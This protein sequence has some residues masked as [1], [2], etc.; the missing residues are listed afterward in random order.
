M[1]SVGWAL[2]WEFWRKGRWIIIIISLFLTMFVLIK[3]LEIKD[4]QKFCV[5][6]KGYQQQM[7]MMGMEK[8]YMEER[9]REYELKID[10]E[11][12]EFPLFLILVLG[13]TIIGIPHDK[14]RLPHRLFTLPISTRSLVTR[15]F[16]NEIASIM[17]L[18]LVY[19]GFFVFL[20]GKTVSIFGISLFT[21]TSIITIQSFL[22]LT[23]SSPIIGIPLLLVMSFSLFLWF[24]A[25][26]G[27]VFF[28]GINSTWKNLEPDQGIFMF[29][30]VILSYI[31]AM[32]AVA[33]ERVKEN[34]SISDI[35]ELLDYKIRSFF[36]IRKGK[37]KSPTKAQ[38]WFEW[39]RQG[40]LMP[41]I[42]LLFMVEF[43]ILFSAGIAPPDSIVD[44]FNFPFFII[45]I[46]L[47]QIWGMLIAKTNPAKKNF[48]LWSFE[49]TRPL[50][51]REISYAILKNGAVNILLT[52]LILIFGVIFAVA[53]NYFLGNASFIKNIGNETL[54]LYPLNLE[55]KGIRVLIFI[56][57]CFLI[58]SWILMGISSAIT[59]MGKRTFIVLFWTISCTVL[60]IFYFFILIGTPWWGVFLLG[61]IFF[62]VLGRGLILEIAFI[63]FITRRRNLIEREDVLNNF[64]LWAIGTVILILLFFT[65]NIQ[66][67]DIV[68]FL[69]GIIALALSPFALA[70]LALHWNR[71]R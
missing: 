5:E 68:I 3:K 13:L 1:R 48:S 55:I 39:Q 50:S 41:F 52:G 44:I 51:C 47:S 35:S 26:H 2:T 66:H 60:C 37:F 42:I 19:T 58:I 16:I 54:Q 69:S 11:I 63:F 34:L 59:L 29:S 4:M 46:F 33:L 22:W 15:I 14:L 7:K 30:C 8:K 10:Q 24:A 62:P 17:I 53:L 45:L 9:I 61:E 36:I 32:K 25:Q 12:Y 20:T 28:S 31:V 18:S 23:I 71:H 27:S 38:F 70:P 49:A 43:V 6:L 57:S 21:T 65:K 64:K 56:F 40:F 67:I